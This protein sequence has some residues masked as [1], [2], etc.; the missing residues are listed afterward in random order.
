MD[1]IFEPYFSTKE[2]TKGTG[3]GLA[4][5]HG[6]V[7]SYGGR[8]TVT[9]NIDQGTT[10]TIYLPLCKLLIDQNDQTSQHPPLTGGNEHLL[11]IDDEREIA[12][13][14][15]LM[16]TPLGYSIT[17]MTDSTEALEWFSQNPNRV[18]LVVT[19][20]TMPKITGTDL[21]KKMLSLRPD[22]PIILCTGYSDLINEEQAKKMGISAFIMKPLDQQTVAETVR[23]CL[24]QK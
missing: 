19:D 24:E 8:I 15:K 17:Q 22:L 21:S 12:Q 14:L 11:V 2:A 9:S 23:N 18:D 6:I 20:M 4:V 16:L 7:T 5:V 10:F 3:L 1:R 13:L